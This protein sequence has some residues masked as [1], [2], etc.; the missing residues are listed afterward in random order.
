[1]RFLPAD[2]R[3]TVFK[4]PPAM[5]PDQRKPSQRCRDGRLTAWKVLVLA[6]LA[7]AAPLAAAALTPAMAATIYQVHTGDKDISTLVLRG[8]IV[9]G[10]LARLQRVTAKVPPGQR[11][12]LMLDSPGGSIDEGIAIGRYVY[13]AKITTIAI[14]RLGCRST[15]AFVFLPA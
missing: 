6:V 15:C 8:Q 4:G 14:Q 11:I 3:T 1:M 5:K 9:A 7:A 10:D 2:I 13:A 12:A